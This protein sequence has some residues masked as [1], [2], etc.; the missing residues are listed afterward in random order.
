MEPADVLGLPDA[1]RVA[2]EI[3]L[4]LAEQ[5]GLEVRSVGMTQVQLVQ[6]AR[7]SRPRATSI[8]DGNLDGMST[9]L[10]LRILAAP[11]VRVRLKC[12]RAA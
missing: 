8:L 3:R 6:L 1:D 9:D 5:I 7:V 2:I 12:H 10:F 11:G 4:E